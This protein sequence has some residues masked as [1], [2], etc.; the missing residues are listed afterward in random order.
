[1]LYLIL[2]HVEDIDCNGSVILHLKVIQRSYGLTT[3]NASRDLFLNQMNKNI[4]EVID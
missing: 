3:P 2:H 1:M 4:V